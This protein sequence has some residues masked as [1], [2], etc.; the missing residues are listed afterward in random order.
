[1]VSTAV[2]PNNTGNAT[3]SAGS[4]I[5]PTAY[6]NGTNLTNSNEGG[7]YTITYYNTSP[8][9]T[10]TINGT[11]NSSYNFA[12]TNTTTG[13]TQYQD[14]TPTTNSSGQS[15]YSV[16]FG[17]QNNSTT[18][19]NAQNFHVAITGTPQN[20]DTFTANVLSPQSNS[21]P[22][23]Y[24]TPMTLTQMNAIGLQGNNAN[25][26]N[27]A[28]I[29]NNNVNINGSSESIS[30][31]YASIVSNI[32]TAAQST[33]SNYTN[34]NSVLTNLNNQLS[35]SV[36]VNMNNQMTNLTNYQNSYQ[37]AAALSKSAQTIMTALLNMVP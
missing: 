8:L 20:G 26:L 23:A 9:P 2:N 36:G 27:I 19:T 5:N 34:S 22:A 14:I 16:F 12:I 33:N 15:V 29:Q 3:I 18:T 4:V 25:A 21:M 11:A 31:Y 6:T 1:A 10:A 13:Q 7:Q 24:S 30:N 37:A 17:N 32:G 28:N 35:S